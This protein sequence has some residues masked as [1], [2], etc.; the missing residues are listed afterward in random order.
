MTFADDQFNRGEAQANASWSG[1]VVPTVGPG[2]L[3]PNQRANNRMR[4][5]AFRHR[6]VMNAAFLEEMWEKFVLNR[7]L[8]PEV[9]I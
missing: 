6:G 9:L 7:N 8:S 5:L 2:W 3:P 1:Y 4:S